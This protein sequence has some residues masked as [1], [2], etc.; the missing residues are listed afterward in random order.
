MI[1]LDKNDKKPYILG[2]QKCGLNSLI[3][4]LGNEVNTVSEDIS[5]PDSIK[6]FEAYKDT[7]KPVIIIRKDRVKA[8]Y[9]MYYYF[10]YNEKYTLEQF[11]SINIPHKQY[12][13]ENPIHRTD[14][15]RHIKP[16][17]KYNPIIYVLEDMPDSFPHE[18]KGGQRTKQPYPEITQEKRNLINSYLDAQ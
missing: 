5:S 12:G 13:N 2:F 8:I 6:K 9:S 18:N 1:V 17:L 14:F 15:E 16:F 7:H 11:L 10:G 3:K 4:W